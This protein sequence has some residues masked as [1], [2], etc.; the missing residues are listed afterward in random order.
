[1]NYLRVYALSA[2]GSIAVSAICVALDYPRIA[3]VPITL[4][5][6]LA[7]AYGDK[8]MKLRTRSTELEN[9]KDWVCWLKMARPRHIQMKDNARI[10]RNTL[11]LLFGVV[12]AN[13]IIGAFLISESRSAELRVYLWTSTFSILAG[14]IC[15]AEL[16]RLTRKAHR[17]VANG[18]I[19]IGKVT[20]LRTNGP[21]RTIAYQF[22]DNAGQVVVG[23][24]PDAVGSLEVG[25]SIPVF[26][27]P[28]RPKADHIALCRSPY[29]LIANTRS[30]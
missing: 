14:V 26:Y 9:P 12:W 29:T 30:S 19:G 2:F 18:A 13:Q 1:M 22:I 5:F 4:S 3:V 11:L 17:L 8:A 10:A 24:G 15:L 21:R 7:I 6:V 28:E 16:W 20:G 27:N 23:S 25:N